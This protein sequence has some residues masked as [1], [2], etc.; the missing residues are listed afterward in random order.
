[1]PSKFCMYYP[2]MVEGNICFWIETFEAA[3][4]KARETYYASLS[5]LLNRDAKKSMTKNEF[6]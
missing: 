6:V 1:M 4:D 3:H 5:D 2:A